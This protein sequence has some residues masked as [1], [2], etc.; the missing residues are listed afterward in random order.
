MSHGARLHLFTVFHLNLAF[1]SI[2]EEQRPEVVRRCYW[3][4]LRLARDYGLSLGIEAPGF[5]L[6]A[7]AVIDPSWVAELRR[8]VCE[9]ACEFIGSG[10]AQAI[11]PLLPAD[12]NRA[13]LR[14]GN[15]AYESLLGFRPQTAMINEQA[16]S[17]GLLQHYLDAGYKAI[18]ME[19][20]NPASL[21]PDWDHEWRYLPQV[22]VG[23]HGEEVPVVWG[24]SIAFQKFQRYAHGELEIAEYVSYLKEHCSGATRALSLYCSDVEIF[25]F[26][27]G[28]YHTEEALQQEGEWGRI[29]RL[30]QVLLA[31]GGFRFVRP[32][33]VVG[34]L[35]EPGAGHR[36]QLESPKQPIPVKK[37]GK[38]NV[39]RWAVTGRDSLG[40]NTACWRIREALKRKADASD[41]S[42]RELCYLWSSDFR[43]HITADRWQKYT[44]RLSAFEKQVGV[45]A[46][47]DMQEAPPTWGRG[48]L[49]PASGLSSFEREGRWL[50]AQTG[51]ARVRLNCRRGLSIDGLWLA[52]L[53][54]PPLCGTL[55]HGYYQ[56]IAMGA[57]WYTGHVVLEPPGQA[58]V[59]DLN[60]VEPVAQVAD[61]GDI[62]IEGTVIAPCGPVVKRIRLCAGE[63]R[64]EIVYT[65][66]WDTV[67]V[68]SLRLLNVTLH[69]EAFSRT[70]LRYRTHNG[71][72]NPEELALSGASVEHGEPISSLVSASGGV[73]V[74]E[75]WVEIG[76]GTRGLRVEVDKTSAALIGFLTYREVG[77]SYFCRLA[78]SAAEVDETRRQ[79]L[80]PFRRV[81]RCA[82]SLATAPDTDC[83][84]S[85]RHQC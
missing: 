28:R 26:R 34:M 18:V 55:P 31:D 56:D 14:L 66:D 60:P 37:Q 42:W 1:S 57:D 59:T 36:L 64:V 10:Y 84:V 78:L 35:G 69:P 39:T 53:D 15:Q 65:F 79:P 4:L 16:Y 63:P 83:S 12:A 68:G 74:T 21:H 23:Q 70:G 19:W 51:A 50:T 40:I 72:R 77:D 25:D 5:T 2:E 13:N 17:A 22:A 67:P 11:G 3:P 82:I 80:P 32:S 41:S 6:E 8:L 75:G 62:V 76:D 30:F 46:P 29:E 43:T 44:G 20:D 48:S 33:E 58:K 47:A 7:A 73:G 81:I 49:A 45:G 52:S 24:N 71:G 54:G 38:Y 85:T 9:G 61:S 27:P